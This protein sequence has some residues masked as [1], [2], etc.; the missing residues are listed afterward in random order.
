[1]DETDFSLRVISS[2]RPAPKRLQLIWTSCPIDDFCMT[3]FGNWFFSLF[4]NV[5]VV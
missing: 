4:V 3:H 5:A 2:G 1:M